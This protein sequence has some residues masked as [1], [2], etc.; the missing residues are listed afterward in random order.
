M[1]TNAA[2]GH[3]RL[4]QLDLLRAV[5]I[6]FVFFYHGLIVFGGDAMNWRDTILQ[7]AH[8]NLAYLLLLPVNFGWIGVP[9]FFVLS[10]FVI[11][12]SFLRSAP[13]DPAAYFRRRFWRIY[14]AYFVALLVFGTRPLL[15]GEWRDF[16][17]HAL[18]LH[19]LFLGSLLSLNP[20]FWSLAVEA[21]FYALYPL[22]LA[23]RA[24]FG[25]R[26]AFAGAVAV[27]LITRGIVAAI[28]LRSH[29]TITPATQ[30][31]A[32]T[33]AFYMDWVAGA[34]VAE[35]IVSGVSVFGRARRAALPALLLAAAAVSQVRFGFVV[36]FSLWSLFWAGVIEAIA[37]KPYTPAPR[38][39]RW[40]LPLG[41]GSYSVY[42]YHQPILTALLTA[43]SPLFAASLSGYLALCALGLAPTLC[44][45]YLSYQ[46]VEKRFTKGVPSAIRAV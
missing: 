25:I 31:W 23:T 40:L 17:L 41:A 19:N 34:C 1:R 42:L 14:P 8:E 45:A 16:T 7:R 5:A 39:D 21:Q 10:G 3:T 20:S 33:P 35:G 2:G 15:A 24:R 30:T 18:L 22:L 9:L 27:S 37:S 26:S 13:F 11:H 38:R 4:P 46:F 12:Y 6:L 44:A 28:L 43:L 32:C 29:G 36:S